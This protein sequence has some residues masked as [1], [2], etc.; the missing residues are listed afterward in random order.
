M[1]L[2]RVLRSDGSDSGL[3]FHGVPGG[4]EFTSFIM[5]L[6]NV[7]G[8]GQALD[9][10]TMGR[11]KALD[12]PTDMQIFVSLSCTMCPELVLSLIHI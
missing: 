11:I 12:A 9:G 6:Y 1:P 3:A 10:E 2:V 7:A 4:H 5:G 8:P